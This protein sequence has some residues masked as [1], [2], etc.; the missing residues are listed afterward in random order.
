MTNVRATLVKG[1]TVVRQYD[2]GRNAQTYDHWGYVHLAAGSH[3][4]YLYIDRG[5]AEFIEAR[6]E[7]DA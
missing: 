4:F 6:V 7:E 2:Y 1:G 3:T 5:T